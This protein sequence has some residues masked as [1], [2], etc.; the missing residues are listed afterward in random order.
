MI[1]RFKAKEFIHLYLIKINSVIKNK[2]LINLYKITKFKVEIQNFK[3]QIQLI[4]K[5]EKNQKFIKEVVLPIMK[6]E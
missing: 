1:L 5:K 4:I 6:I 3:I 2:S